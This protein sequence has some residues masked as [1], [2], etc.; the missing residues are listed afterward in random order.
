[1][2]GIKTLAFDTG[3]TILDWHSGIVAALAEAGARSDVAADWHALAND[4]RRNS[5]G[6]ILGSVDPGFTIDWVHRVVL[7]EI[8]PAHGVRG[9]AP[10]HRAAMARARSLAGFRA[11]SRNPPARVCLRLVYDP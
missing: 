3:G 2:D 1:M 5:L 11:G 8:L 4:Y 7:D 9:R 10:G 6:R